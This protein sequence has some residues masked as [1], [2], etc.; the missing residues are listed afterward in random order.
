MQGFMKIQLFQNLFIG[1]TVK[2]NSISESY[3]GLWK[4]F[5]VNNLSRGFENSMYSK[6]L[7]YKDLK[8]FIRSN[9]KFDFVLFLWS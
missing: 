1:N 7:A 8:R 4:I 6:T 2:D 9:N 5:I 3:G